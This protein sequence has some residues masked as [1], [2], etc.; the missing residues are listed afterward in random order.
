MAKDLETKEQRKQA[1]K[2][3]PDP[4]VP[5]ERAKSAQHAYEEWIKTKRKQEK[6]EKELEK[7]RKEEEAAGYLVR[8]RE[9]CDEAFKRYHKCKINSK[10]IVIPFKILYW[11]I[12]KFTGQPRIGSNYINLQDVPATGHGKVSCRTF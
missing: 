1:E 2:N 7:S 5:V 12:K 10:I 9:L 4:N 8:D 3:K 6:M 11:E